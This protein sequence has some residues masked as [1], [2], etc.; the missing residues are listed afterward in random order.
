MYKNKLIPLSLLTALVLLTSG[1]QEGSQKTAQKVE[2]TQKEAPVKTK[3]IVKKQETPKVIE[4]KEEKKEVQQ[5]IA[6]EVKE[7]ETTT[8]STE[9]KVG[10]A[11]KGQKIFGKKLK[12]V[13]GVNGGVIAKKHT[14]SEWEKIINNGELQKEIST[15]CPGATIKEK[16]VP[17]IGA[18][19][20]QFANDSGNVPSC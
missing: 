10:N 1:C 16:Y 13:C 7:K 6:T 4:K 9:K 19:F 8:T 18:F 14:Q 11:S 15:L 2:P 17:D 12:G 3:E 5:T 20:I